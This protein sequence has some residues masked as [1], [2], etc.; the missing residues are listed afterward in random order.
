MN[1]TMTLQT[2]NSI[3]QHSSIYHIALSAKNKEISF[4]NI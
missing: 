3:S 2:F 1:S 4:S